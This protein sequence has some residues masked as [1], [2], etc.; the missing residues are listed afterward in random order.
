MTD[1]RGGLS[2]P[3]GAHVFVEPEEDARHGDI[4]VAKLDRHEQATVKKL[5]I[6]P[7][8]AFLMP[9]NPQYDKIAINEE[10]RIVGVVK[11]IVIVIQK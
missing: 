1:T 7:P 3:H 8:T 6:D 5:L 10:C 9:L 2:I 11:Q 4:V